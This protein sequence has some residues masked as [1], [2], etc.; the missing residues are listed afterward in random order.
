MKYLSV[1]LSLIVVL[2]FT[3]NTINAQSS[4]K[5]INVMDYGAIPD[6]STDNTL[7]FQKAV[8]LASSQGSLVHIPAGKFLIKGSIYLT[9]VALV[10]ENQAPRS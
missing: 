4:Q 5:S 7:A 8:D 9:G 10:G 3:I 2:I 6:G 1:F